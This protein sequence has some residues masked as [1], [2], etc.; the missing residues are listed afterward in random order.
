MAAHPA[1]IVALDKLTRK[2]NRTPG[3][4][5]RIHFTDVG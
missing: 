5:N 1:A 2:R 3:V 4:E